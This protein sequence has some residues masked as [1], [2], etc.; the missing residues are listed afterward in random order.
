M[1]AGIDFQ[2]LNQGEGILKV[3]S[4]GY[5]A[6]VFY[7]DD[8]IVAQG[9]VDRFKIRNRGGLLGN[10]LDLS[11]IHPLLKGNGGQGIMVVEV[12]YRV[13]GMDMDDNVFLR[14]LLID[15]HMKGFLR[16]RFL[17]SLYFITFSVYYQDIILL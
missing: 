13:G 8:I 17:I 6:M 4:H 14:E 11:Q 1:H 5:Y 3:L 7:D 12:V 15:G 9:R 16:G 2:E 10:G